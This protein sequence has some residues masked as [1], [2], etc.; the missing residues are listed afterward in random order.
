MFYQKSTNRVV[1]SNIVANSPSIAIAF[2]YS[3][4]NKTVAIGTDD[5]DPTKAVGDGTPTGVMNNTEFGTFGLLPDPQ[6]DANFFACAGSFPPLESQPTWKYLCGVLYFDGTTGTATTYY[7]FTGVHVEQGGNCLVDD[8]VITTSSNQNTAIYATDFNSF[9]IYKYD[10]ITDT[11]SVINSDMSLLCASYTTQGATSC[12]GYPAAQGPNGIAL[13]TDSSDTEWLII[14][15]SNSTYGFVKMSLDGTTAIKLERSVNTPQSI[16]LF[17]FDGI[18]LYG[19]KRSSVIYA[20]TSDPYP[21]DSAMTIGAVQVFSSIDDWNS[22]DIRTVYN[23]S[24]QQPPQNNRVTAVRFGG[25]NDGDLVIQCNNNF[26]YGG[27]QYFNV[28]DD[29]AGDPIAN[30]IGKYTTNPQIS[31]PENILYDPNNNMIVFGSLGNP[32]LGLVGYPYPNR[33][34]NG[35]ISA[36]ISYGNDALHE[37]IPSGSLGAQNALGNVLGLILSEMDNCY[38]YLVS[39][40][41]SN[42]KDGYLYSV[43]LC[44]NK[45]VDSTKLPEPSDG[46]DS[47]PNDLDVLNGYIYITDTIANRVLRVLLDDNHQFG[48]TE[49]VIEPERVATNDPNVKFYSPDGIRGVDNYLLISSIKNLVGGYQAPIFKYVPS[50]NTMTVVKDTTG[51][52]NDFDKIIFNHDKSILFGTRNDVNP[53]NYYSD[54]RAK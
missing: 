12:T 9:Q 8:L 2:P 37:Y 29:V 4:A 3:Y 27:P 15:I 16:A 26:V 51:V 31:P 47:L 54:S 19:S 45:I 18:A 1:S 53:L 7:N 17:S 52:L 49:V 33:E 50:T 36:P 32:S 5:Y 23:A 34:P 38:A 25:P 28:L 21:D 14:A 39:G 22:F 6:N 20:A 44:E 11:P 10:L 46:S 35:V 40:V 48:A 41:T 42:S 30:T 13:Y 43:N 24:C